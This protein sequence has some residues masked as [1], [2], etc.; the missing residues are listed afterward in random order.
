VIVVAVVA[1]TVAALKQ[2]SWQ[3]AGFAAPDAP[4][5]MSGSGRRKEYGAVK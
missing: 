1:G 2:L 4:A 3:S 5:A